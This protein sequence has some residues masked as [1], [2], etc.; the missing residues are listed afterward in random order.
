MLKYYQ[1]PLSTTWSKRVTLG[2]PKWIERQMRQRGDPGEDWLL[3]SLIS[4][5]CLYLCSSSG[6]KISLPINFPYCVTWFHL[7]F[8]HL[9]PNNPDHA[10]TYLCCLQLIQAN[11]WTWYTIDQVIFMETSVN[12]VLWSQG[13]FHRK[14]FLKSGNGIDLHKHSIQNTP[15]YFLD[16][17]ELV[18]KNKFKLLH[19][20]N[21]VRHWRAFWN[22][23]SCWYPH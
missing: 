15:S 1:T 3:C 12:A 20:H 6:E 16:D 18:Y 4:E 23:R 5:A 14:C 17:M 10:I 21:S 22:R 13:T 7:N 9:K 2:R 8:R 19:S 11:F